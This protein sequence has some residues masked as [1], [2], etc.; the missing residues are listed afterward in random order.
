MQNKKRFPDRTFHLFQGILLLC[1]SKPALPQFESFDQAL[2]FKQKAWDLESLL[3]SHQSIPSIGGEEEDHNASQFAEPWSTN[4]FFDSLPGGFFPYLSKLL[5]TYDLNNAQDLPIPE[6]FPPVPLSEKQSSGSP[7]EY[8]RPKCEFIVHPEIDLARLVASFT[9]PCIFY[10]LP[11]MYSASA[12]VS[13]KKGHKISALSSLKKVSDDSNEDHEIAPDPAAPSSQQQTKPAKRRVIPVLRLSPYGSITIYRDEEGNILH[14][15]P[16][17]SEYPAARR[18]V[19]FTL[20]PTL[21]LY[22]DGRAAT[23]HYQLRVD[24]WRSVLPAH[25]LTQYPVLQ[26]PFGFND[27]ILFE[28]DEGSELHDLLIDLEFM[29]LL[30]TGCQQVFASHS[31]LMTL[32]N[33][34]FTNGAPCDAP[35]PEEFNQPIISISNGGGQPRTVPEETGNNSPGGDPPKDKQEDDKAPPKGHQPPGDGPPPPPGGNDQNQESPGGEGGAVAIVVT[36]APLDVDLVESLARFFITDPHFTANFQ[37]FLNILDRALYGNREAL[38]NEIVRVLPLKEKVFKDT[39]YLKAIAE[40][41][42]KKTGTR[43]PQLKGSNTIRVVI[44]AALQQGLSP[45]QILEIA[46][47]AMKAIPGVK[48]L[49]TDENHTP[50]TAPELVT[51]EMTTSGSIDDLPLPKPAEKALE[52]TRSKRIKKPVVPPAEAVD[53]L[54]EASA[55]AKDLLTP[56]MSNPDNVIDVLIGFIT[57]THPDHEA[58]LLALLSKMFAVSKPPKDL[59]QL[60]KKIP[61]EARKRAFSGSN[62]MQIIEAFLQPV[63]AGEVEALRGT[64]S[65]PAKSVEKPIEVPLL[66]PL[67]RETPPE[68]KTPSEHSATPPIP[69]EPPPDTDT[70]ENKKLA[71]K[72][73]LAKS[74]P[75]KKPKEEV[76]RL[77]KMMALVKSEAAMRELVQ[78]VDGNESL[79]NTRKKIISSWKKKLKLKVS[80]KNLEDCWDQLE[81][82]R[83][84]KTIWWSSDAGQLLTLFEQAFSTAEQPQLDIYLTPRFEALPKKDDS[85]EESPGEEEQ[86]IKKSEPEKPVKLPTPPPEKETR[87]LTPISPLVTSVRASTLSLASSDGGRSS[88]SST[89]AGLTFAHIEELKPQARQLALYLRIDISA[90][91]HIIAK[92]IVEA[93]DK[94]GNLYMFAF[95]SYSKLNLR[96]KE[97]G[98]ATTVLAADWKKITSYFKSRT[99]LAEFA[100]AFHEVLANKKDEALYP[101]LQS[102]VPDLAD[103]SE[104]ENSL[105]DWL[106]SDTEAH[107]A[108]LIQMLS[109]QPEVL[110]QFQQAFLLVSKQALSEAATPRVT[111]S[112]LTDNARIILS[113][114][115]ENISLFSELLIYLLSATEREQLANALQM[116][117]TN[118]EFEDD[119]LDEAETPVPAA[120]SNTISPLPFSTTPSTD[121][122]LLYRQLTRQLLTREIIALILRNIQSFDTQASILS[123]LNNHISGGGQFTFDGNQLVSPSETDLGGLTEFLSITTQHAETVATIL[124]QPIPDDEI[125]SILSALDV[126]TRPHSGR[127][128]RRPRSRMSSKLMSPAP[129]ITSTFTSA[130][131]LSEAESVVASPIH[132]ALTPHASAVAS[133]EAELD[134]NE[135]SI[136][137]LGLELSVILIALRELGLSEAFGQLITELQ[138]PLNIAFLTESNFLAALV[139]EK[140]DKAFTDALTNIRGGTVTKRKKRSLRSTTSFKVRVAASPLHTILVKVVERIPEEDLENFV[141][142][143]AALHGDVLAQNSNPSRKSVRKQAERLSGRESEGEEVESKPISKSTS[144]RSLFLAR[145]KI[146][147]EATES[148]TA[149]ASLVSSL[150]N[151]PQHAKPQDQPYDHL[152]GMKP[153]SMPVPV[154]WQALQ[155]G[156][157]IP[158]SLTGSTMVGRYTNAILVTIRA[159]HQATLARH[160]QNIRILASAISLIK[161]SRDAKL[162][163]QLAILLTDYFGRVDQAD[164]LIFHLRLT[165]EVLVHSKKQNIIPFEEVP[166]FTDVTEY[167]NW[168]LNYYFGTYNSS[169]SQP[170]GSS[171]S[172]A[173]ALYTSLSYDDSRPELHEKII[174]LA[175]PLTAPGHQQQQTSPASNPLLQVTMASPSYQHSGQQPSRSISQVVKILMNHTLNSEL[176]DIL[177]QYLNRYLDQ[178][179]QFQPGPEQY[180]DV[181]SLIQ[182]SSQNQDQLYHLLAQARRLLGTEG[183]KQFVQAI[184]GAAARQVNASTEV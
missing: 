79:K 43:F 180:I 61:K 77:E 158:R 34:L 3:T 164:L 152:A 33:I 23:T 127:H 128:S 49:H 82:K 62:A 10:L 4:N 46:S 47:Y 52:R 93:G 138:K 16:M 5:W 126:S 113:Q 129:S 36:P 134:R 64:L 66:P 149:G 30:Q 175:K 157:Q 24:G 148:L 27:T 162:I 184:I 172:L 116:L 176:I 68:S 139:P 94:A 25:M 124:G 8:G 110:A 63:S 38:I 107:F 32:S 86:D 182:A 21:R 56:A 178:L 87:T 125:Q 29:P 95:S 156:A 122:D 83:R 45:S 39:F 73:Q 92:A 161:R 171:R 160:N 59:K 177:N 163:Q 137:L 114:S 7:D 75:E 26:V 136:H 153:F 6:P 89:R 98:E 35:F 147:T 55:L 69:I 143:F 13:L 165:Q 40:L 132:V 112:Q 108:Q 37:M 67:N 103:A 96:L 183:W 50:L 133:I 9:E 179:S 20:S 60:W 174:E 168:I 84:T 130:S 57:E 90:R 121:R 65:L 44:E 100:R 159:H 170:T 135:I 54:P 99:S 17:E 78:W 141:K 14:V 109:P 120:L 81:E 31:P 11:E 91:L 117:G 173:Q 28:F 131:E 48:W 118:D 142:K 146:K 111:D 104:L 12:T 76:P 1:C 101:L 145:Q 58:A 123:F 105:N 71:V 70:T 169:R 88:G 166:Q 167:F 97:F 42:A 74:K 15:K 51:L 53:L 106:Q 102:L 140:S 85:D 144:T 115:P 150:P 181:I 72:E 41:A 80:C 22:L 151:S 155:L 2:L 18:P 154:Y 119:I 19:R